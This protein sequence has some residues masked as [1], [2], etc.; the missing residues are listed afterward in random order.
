MEATGSIPVPPTIQ[1]ARK[2]NNMRT[3]NCLANH[4]GLRF[5][6][7]VL[8]R[9]RAFQLDTATPINWR[10]SFGFFESFMARQGGPVA[11]LRE[12]WKA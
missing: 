12:F 3:P 6:R 8:A 9:N 2:N 11:I 5:K 4:L 1:K 7:L 10:E